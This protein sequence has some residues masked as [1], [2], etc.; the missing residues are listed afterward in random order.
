MGNTDSGLPSDVQLVKEA[1]K[2]YQFIQQLNFTPSIFHPNNI[3]LSIIRYEKYWLPFARNHPQELLI[4]PIDIELIWVAHM[5][6]HL[7]YEKDC[8]AI[9]SN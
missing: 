4:A 7:A 5:L 1:K 2:H 3:K 8:L 9:A 6:N